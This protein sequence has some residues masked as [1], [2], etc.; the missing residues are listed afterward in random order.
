MVSIFQILGFDAEVD[1]RLEKNWDF[2]FTKYLIFIT[3]DQ[4][5]QLSV[6]RY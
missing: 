3:V 6:I 2:F 4:F 5:I 1:H